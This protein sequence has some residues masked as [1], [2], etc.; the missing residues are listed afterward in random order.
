MCK[1][2]IVLGGAS[3]TGK[4]EVAQ[5]V[6]AETGR[7]YLEGDD[8]HPQQ[9]VEK[10]K[11]GIALS[12]ED[13]YPWLGL[14]CGQIAGAV[15]RGEP[16][17]MSCS[18]LKKRYRQMLQLAGPVKI[19]FL[20]APFDVVV[21]RVRSRSGHWFGPILVQSQFDDLELPDAEEGVTILD[22]ERSPMELA[23]VIIGH[24]RTC[25]V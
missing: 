22:A 20:H 25:D 4:T 19:Y 15:A 17:V 2:C 7:K 3:G 18:A 10:M 5:K 16:I 13:R 21:E 9:N 1:H 8:F 6:K 11:A 23:E 12:D 14:L 24:I